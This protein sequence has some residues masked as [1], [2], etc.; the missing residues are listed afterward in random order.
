M[1]RVVEL[2]APSAG[3]VLAGL[4]CGVSPE[5]TA[6]AA[7]SSDSTGAATTAQAPEPTFVGSTTVQYIME[8]DV[9]NWPSCSTWEQDCP[10]GQKCTFVANDGGSTFNDM[11]CVDIMGDAVHG[12]P[13]MVPGRQLTGDDTCALGHLCWFVD[14]EAGMGTCMALC[15]G[16]PEAAFCEPYKSACEFAAEGFN[17]CLPTC[18]PVVQ[19]CAADRACYVIHGTT[20]CSWLISQGGLG[21]VCEYINACAPGLQCISGELWPDCEG[22][23]C[24]APFCDVSAPEC[25][26]AGTE[27]VPIFDT[28]RPWEVNYGYCM[29]P[30]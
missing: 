14:H 15:Q 2:L 18:D 27:C 16:T 12:E 22:D 8:P 4:A 19:D 10:D 11:Q 13:C 3:L 1:R 17:L 6:T 21:E 30:G 9:G 25:P 29:V 28:P 23:K 7:A 5:S 20:R 26:Y 24:C